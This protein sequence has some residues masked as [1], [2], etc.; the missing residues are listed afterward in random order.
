[1]KTITGYQCKTCGVVMY[2]QHYR[3][4]GCGGRDFEEI[5]PTGQASL[6]TYTVLNEL[7]WGIDERGRVI[8]V[9]EFA[10]GIKAMG[11]IH[12]EDI[13]LGMTLK[14]AWESVRVLYGEK[15]YGLIF[16]AAE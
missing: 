11:L 14:P 13:H 3:C 4:L 16:Q 9:V 8:G 15:V 10:N 7:P 6:I 12:A 5:T 2:P 1:M